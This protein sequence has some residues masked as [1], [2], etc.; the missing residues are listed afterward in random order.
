MR[1]YIE[2]YSIFPLLTMLSIHLQ[3]ITPAIKADTAPMIIG[4]ISIDALPTSSDILRILS[5]LAPKIGINT[6][7]K[8]KRIALDL[9][10]PKN[11]AVLMVAPLRLIPGKM[12]I[13][14]AM[15]I[16]RA[17][18]NLTSLSFFGTNLVRNNNVAVISSMK[19]INATLP[20]KIDSI[21]SSKSKPT[22][23]VGIAEANNS[24]AKRISGFHLNR[25]KFV[26]NDMMSRQNT[27]TTLK[28]VAPC[29]IILKVKKS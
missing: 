13:V 17:L 21:C 23:A 20:S 16:I 24:K 2:K 1:Q 26:I 11:K 8:E 19:P 22:M 25:K 28:N 3:A 15:P 29:T 9:S 4:A 10:I 27:K 14:W 7:R 5:K 18:F 12:A 6:I